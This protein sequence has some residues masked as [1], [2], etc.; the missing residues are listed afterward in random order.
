MNWLLS[1]ELKRVVLTRPAGQNVDMAT[2][3]DS[4]GIPV[5]ELPM[6]EIQA[7]EDSESI[8]RIRQQFETLSDCDYTLFVSANAVNAAFQFCQ[9]QGVKWPKEL[10]CLGMG[11]STEARIIEAGWR[12]VPI[13]NTEGSNRSLRSEDM[14]EQA[15]AQ[16]VKGLSIA[17][18][19]GEGGREYMA[20]VLAERGAKVVS[21]SLY[22]RQKPVVKPEITELHLQ[23]IANDPRGSVIVLASA[24][25]LYNWSAILEQ[26]GF[27]SIK[28][29]LTLL[30]PSTRVANEA[31]NLGYRQIEVAD[32]ASSAAFIAALNGIAAT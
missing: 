26:A 17:I 16:N 1:D 10:A 29:E 3:L 13:H 9:Q 31:R 4:A 30:V 23:H 20:S 8:G 19:K 15:W 28:P 24:D 5:I 21:I 22:R 32:G 12:L 25:T 7:L 2:T 14:M 11:S 27:D 18:I 6:L